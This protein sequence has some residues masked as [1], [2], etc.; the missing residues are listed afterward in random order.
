MKTEKIEELYKKNAEPYEL[1]GEIH[2][3][4]MELEQFTRAINQSE[5]EWYY[6][7]ETDLIFITHE[8]ESV[9][10]YLKKIQNKIKELEND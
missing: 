1:G 5:L 8:G 10:E 3:D 7:L 6:S 2:F 9:S 4:M